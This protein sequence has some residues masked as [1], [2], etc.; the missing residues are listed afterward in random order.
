MQL[1]ARWQAGEPPHHSVP[2]LLRATIAERELAHPDAGS[3]TL[4][5]LEGRPVCTLDDLEVVSL[6]SGGEIRVAPR[7]TSLF[8]PSDDPAADEHDD[9]DWLN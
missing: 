3:W 2:E 1:G 7:A 6:G 8:A 9:D 5:W 4:T